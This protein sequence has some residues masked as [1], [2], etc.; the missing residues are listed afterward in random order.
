MTAQHALQILTK[1]VDKRLESGTYPR[2]VV[3]MSEMYLNILADY[4]KPNATIN[5]R[6]V[7]QV[8]DHIVSYAEKSFREDT[9]RNPHEFLVMATYINTCQ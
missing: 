8:A 3:L 7:F 4:L 1:E 2:R 5:E 6:Q 9:E